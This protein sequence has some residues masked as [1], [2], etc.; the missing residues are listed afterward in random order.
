MTTEATTVSQIEIPVE[1]ERFQLGKVLTMTG[2]HMVHD[3]FTAFLN[4]LLPLIIEKLNLSLALAGSLTLFFRLPSLF[5]P[6]IGIWADRI[7]LQMM[8]I[9]APASTAVLMSSIGLAPNYAV[10]ALLLLAAGLS[11][12]TMHVPA[13]VIVSRISGKRKG[14][15]FSIWM[16]G[17]ELART[18]GPL[19][20]VA[21]VSWWTLEG[22]YPVMILGILTSVVLYFRF[23]TYA[24]RP[25]AKSSGLSLGDS[26]RTMVRLILPLTA[27]I[28][29]RSL[30]RASLS[31]FLP[32]FMVMTSAE[33]SLWQGGTAIAVVE[34]AGVLGVLLAGTLSDR[35]SRR[36]VLLVALATAPLLML[37]FLAVDSG[38]WLFWVF[39]ALTG[40]TSLS[41]TPVILAM[42]QEQG[43]EQPATANGMYMGIMF[44]V[45]SG[46]AP[47]LGWIGD[48]AGLQ[49]AFTW[50]AIVGLVAAPL[51]F[52]LPRDS[53]ASHQRT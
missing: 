5:N 22:Y 34:L 3:A 2:G 10:L 44:V 26:W 45:G 46:S 21:A 13:P 7:D 50:A 53:R 40:F 28:A 23:K 35:V 39:L 20:V 1:E 24:A 37:G 15:G 36:I 27:I 19:L 11:S 18:V 25:P 17:G 51:V 29:A 47:L 16:M 6:L 42:V 41:T 31:T 4:P 38:S 12:A 8:V 9:L 52:L 30:M 48:M 49:V 14:T 32:T 33:S 43:H